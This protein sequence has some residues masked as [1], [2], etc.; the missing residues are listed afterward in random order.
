MPRALIPCLALSLAMSGWGRALVTEDPGKPP[1]LGRMWTKDG[2]AVATRPVGRVKSSSPIVEWP[3]KG[4]EYDFSANAVL[5]R[6]L[7]DGYDFLFL[8]YGTGQKGIYRMC[9]LQVAG[10]DRREY[11]GVRHGKTILGDEE[12]LSPFLSGTAKEDDWRRMTEA[13]SGGSPHQR[14]ILGGLDKQSSSFPINVS[15]RR[16]PDPELARGPEGVYEVELLSSPDGRIID[17]VDTSKGR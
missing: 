2:R 8:V 5:V 4:P 12:L 6:F 16:N 17:A 15:T 1:G 10:E 11:S 9:S 13:A 7:G 14:K 3:R